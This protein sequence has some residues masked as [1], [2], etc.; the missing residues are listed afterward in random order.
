M[1]SQEMF[2]DLFGVHVRQLAGVNGVT[3]DDAERIIQIFAE[4]MKNPYMD[5]RHI[6]QRLIENRDVVV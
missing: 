1:I 3:D 2:F 5:E 4:A 6:Y